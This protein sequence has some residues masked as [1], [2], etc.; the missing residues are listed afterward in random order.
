MATRESEYEQFLVSL[1]KDEGNANIVVFEFHGIVE[2]QYQKFSNFVISPFMLDGTI[3]PS[4]NHYFQAAK[5]QGTDDN[6]ILEIIK[7]SNPFEASR[8][9]KSRQHPIQDNWNVKRNEVMK[10]AVKAKFEQNNELKELLLSTCENPIL[11]HNIDDGWWGDGVGC[12][13]TNQNNL[14]KILQYVREQ[15]K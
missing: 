1:H 12:G 11:C 6:W 10:N 13:G 5:F 14:G 2:E 9:G 8:M 4:V 15:L 7:A 3:W